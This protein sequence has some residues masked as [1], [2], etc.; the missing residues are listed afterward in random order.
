M[1]AELWLILS[2]AMI[3]L[4]GKIQREKFGED[5]SLGSPRTG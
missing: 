4:R 2:E 5:C 3:Q 1:H